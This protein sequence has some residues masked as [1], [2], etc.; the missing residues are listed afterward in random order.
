MRAPGDPACLKIELCYPG[1]AVATHHRYRSSCDV[2][3]E[4]ESRHLAF[5]A[6]PARLFVQ[7]NRRDILR[8][9]PFK[10]IFLMLLLYIE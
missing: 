1:E 4:E 2:E 6:P 10:N 5:L 8:L 3:E 7:L 9:M